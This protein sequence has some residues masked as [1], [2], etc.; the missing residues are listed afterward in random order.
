MISLPRD[1]YKYVAPLALKPIVL[2]EDPNRRSNV[3]Q[4]IIG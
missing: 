2:I 1:S 3:V 4:I